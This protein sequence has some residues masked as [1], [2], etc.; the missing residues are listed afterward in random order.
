MP[1][2]LHCTNQIEYLAGASGNEPRGP[3]PGDYI[4]CHEC[5][6]IM[7][8]CEDEFEFRELTEEEREEF[9]QCHPE[10]QRH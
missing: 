3:E 2:C 9:K 10:A 6:H 4:M 7:A 5:G 1:R 8:I